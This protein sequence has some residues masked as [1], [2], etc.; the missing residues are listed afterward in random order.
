[1]CADMW[2]CYKPDTINCSKG[3]QSTVKSTLC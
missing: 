1:M 2:A 3:K